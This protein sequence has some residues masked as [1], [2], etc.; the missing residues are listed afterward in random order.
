MNVTIY[1]IYVAML[2]L[3]LMFATL[4]LHCYRL[5]HDQNADT[6]FTLTEHTIV[7]IVDAVYQ[8]LSLDLS[9]KMVF[10]QSLEWFSS[11]II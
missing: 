8:S 3:V 10:F 7:T 9:I 11:A 2:V 1:L 4:R 6:E 5:V